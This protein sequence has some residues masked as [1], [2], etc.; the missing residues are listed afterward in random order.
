MDGVLSTDGAAYCDRSRLWLLL[1]V[2]EGDHGA[3]LAHGLYVGADGVRW[4]DDFADCHDSLPLQL[5]QRLM[6]E[7]GHGANLVHASNLPSAGSRQNS[8]DGPLQPLLDKGQTAFL[9]HRLACLRVGETRQKA[10]DVGCSDA[11]R[12][13]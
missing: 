2:Q 12:L 13:R 7:E 5:P 1:L 6:L 10:D 11:L 9:A 3:C 4:S 8:D